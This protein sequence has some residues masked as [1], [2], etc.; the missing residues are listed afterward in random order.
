MGR[1][2]RGKGWPRRADGKR[3]RPL[4]PPSEDVRD[5]EYSEQVSFEFD[6]SPALAS[7]V[8]SFEHSDDSMGLSV[9][10]WA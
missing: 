8:G 2:K 9:V 3:K 7:P 6:R 1:G 5:S 10:A 4:S